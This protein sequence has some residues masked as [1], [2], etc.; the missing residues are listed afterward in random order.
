LLRVS[1]PC[2]HFDVGWGVVENV[3]WHFWR[4]QAQF[5]NKCEVHVLKPY[6]PSKAEEADPRLYADNV[7]RLM[8]KEL[9]A[10]LSP[11][12]IPEQQMLKRAGYC[13]EKYGR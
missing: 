2:R 1:S 10:K 6:I 13:V 5:V 3:A 8:A 11:Y 7:R 9:G 4:L 12:G